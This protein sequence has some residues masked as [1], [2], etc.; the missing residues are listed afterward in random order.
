MNNTQLLYHIGYLWWLH[1]EYAKKLESLYRFG[2]ACDDKKEKLQQATW[3]I[4]EVINYYND[5][6]CLT[7]KEICSIIVKAQKLFK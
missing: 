5:C 2:I 3:L 4:E 1:K 6:S 7:E